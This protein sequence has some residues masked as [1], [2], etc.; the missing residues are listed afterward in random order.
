MRVVLDTQDLRTTPLNP[1][2]NGG[3]FAEVRQVS[4]PRLRG[5]KGG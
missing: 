4:F 5:E 3:K 1:P 2:V